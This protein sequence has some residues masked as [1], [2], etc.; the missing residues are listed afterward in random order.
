[1][2]LGSLEEVCHDH[3]QVLCERSVQASEPTFHGHL[4]MISCPPRDHVVNKPGIPYPHKAPDLPSA[5]LMRLLES[6]DNLPLQGEITPVQALRVIRSHPRFGELTPADLKMI[7]EVLKPQ[8]RCYGLVRPICFIRAY[9]VKQCWLT[10]FLD[11][12]PW[13][14]TSSCT[15]PSAKFSLPNSVASTSMI[16]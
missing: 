3:Q 12:V 2:I 1:M 15:T 8:C 9:A 5:D 16:L 6:S 7:E 10:C 4:L 13:W 14:K 11:S